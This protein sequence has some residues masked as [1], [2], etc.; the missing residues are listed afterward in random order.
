MKARVED[1]CIEYILPLQIPI[2]NYKNFISIPYSFVPKGG[3]ITTKSTVFGLSFS[4]ATLALMKSKFP[5]STFSSNW[6]RAT[7]TYF[8]SS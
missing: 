2:A 6:S 1:L 4:L 5:P 3:F 8:S 7:Y